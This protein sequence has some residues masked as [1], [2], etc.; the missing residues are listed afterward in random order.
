MFETNFSGHQKVLGAVQERTSV[1]TGLHVPLGACR[2]VSDGS[3]IFVMM[4]FY[5]KFTIIIR[6]FLIFVLIVTVKGYLADNI[7]PK[8]FTTSKAEIFLSLPRPDPWGSEHLIHR[9]RPT[10]HSLRNGV[11]R[12]AAHSHAYATPQVETG[13]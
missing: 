5:R 11:D 4:K 1:A 3:Q 12:L 6:A 9:E 8:G 10:Q 7:M 13:Q 2:G